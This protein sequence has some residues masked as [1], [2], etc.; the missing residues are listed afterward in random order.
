MSKLFYLIY[1]PGWQSGQASDST[2]M[3]MYSEEKIFAVAI[4]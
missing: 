2:T 1:L 4:W 3:V